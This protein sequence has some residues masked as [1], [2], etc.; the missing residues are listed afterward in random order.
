MAT[1]SRAESGHP[2]CRR[3]NRRKLAA[4]KSLGRA[5]HRSPR[6]SAQGAASPPGS[7]WPPF[8]TSGTLL[9]GL[10]SEEI[11]R[12]IA[13]YRNRFFSCGD[14]EKVLAPR[15]RRCYQPKLGHPRPLENSRGG[16]SPP[17]RTAAFRARLV[18]YED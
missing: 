6:E 8:F 10:S 9:G 7:G 5:R 4:T 12:E 18:F 14:S 13:P 2:L 3:L 15:K 11:L 1:R 16:G 17:G